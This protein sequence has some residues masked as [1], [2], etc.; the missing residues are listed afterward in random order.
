MDL[1]TSM[2]RNVALGR[3]PCASKTSQSTSKIPQFR[4]A[5]GSG[6]LGSEDQNLVV[7]FVNFKLFGLMKPA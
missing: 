7:E 1:T 2:C 3:A 5:M 6:Y 4:A